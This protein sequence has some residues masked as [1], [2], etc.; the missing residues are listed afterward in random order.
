MVNQVQ[1]SWAWPL[2]LPS[3]TLRPS[4]SARSA[5]LV[6]DFHSTSLEN[7]L[8]VTSPRFLFGLVRLYTYEIKHRS[9]F[10]HG[11]KAPGRWG[12]R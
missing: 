8:T 10:I 1:L 6:P 9:D 12:P 3:S 5:S 4:W 2:G 7:Y 11:Q